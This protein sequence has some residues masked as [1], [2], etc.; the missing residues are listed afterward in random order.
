MPPF[1]RPMNQM[2]HGIQ[3]NDQF[4]GILG[5][6]P[7]AHLQQAIGH[8]GRV[9]RQ[10]VAA[11]VPVV[12]QLQPVEG[13]R[14]GQ[15]QPP[16]TGIETVPPQRIFFIAGGGQE[17]IAPQ[18]VV[19]VEVF[20]TQGQPKNPLRQQLAHRVIHKHLL[21]VVA[22]TLGQVVGQA[23]LAVHLPQQQDPAIAGEVAAGKIG[24]HLA[25]AQV[26]KEQPDFRLAAL[27]MDKLIQ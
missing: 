3:I 6:A 4:A 24:H 11:G 10:F 8:L 15:R 18:L 1:L 22:K 7:H 20:V 17:G 14:A 9:V 23:Q 12:G 16:M 27:D 13:G 5:Q 2:P 21:A 26:V 19:I 25:R